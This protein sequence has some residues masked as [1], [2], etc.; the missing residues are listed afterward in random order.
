ME[1]GELSPSLNHLQ[2]TGHLTLCQGVFVSTKWV[3]ILLEYKDEA[4][5]TR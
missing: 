4:T 2:S 3:D 5:D 1:V